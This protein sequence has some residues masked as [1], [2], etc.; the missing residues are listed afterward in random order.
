MCGGGGEGG[1][2]GGERSGGGGE[3]GGGKGGGGEERIV[4]LVVE[5]EDEEEED[6]EVLRSFTN[7]RCSRIT[8]PIEN[9]FRAT[10]A[11]YKNGRVVVEQDDNDEGEEAEEAEEE[12]DEKDRLYPGTNLFSY[13]VFNTIS[14]FRCTAPLTN[15]LYTLISPILK[16][17]GGE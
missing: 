14:S 15:S 11:V 13:E 3:G 1:E 16:R 10:F 9:S 12:K 4:V 2:C 7:T 8:A 5:E 17:I 6:K